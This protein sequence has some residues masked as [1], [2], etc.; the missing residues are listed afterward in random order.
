MNENTFKIGDKVIS[1]VFGEGTILDVD[2]TEDNLY[3]IRVLF[4]EKMLQYFTLTGQYTI[5]EKNPTH[6]I[7]LK[8]NILIQPKQEETIFQIGDKV[9]S[10]KFGVGFVIGLS[11][12]E[13]YPLKVSFETRPTKLELY[14]LQGKYYTEDDIDIQDPTK[15]IS[16]FIESSLNF[17]Q[18][19]KGDEVISTKFG[20]GV[21]KII[22][23]DELYPLY[24]KFSDGEYVCFTKEGYFD[25]DCPLDWNIT[26]IPQEKPRQKAVRQKERTVE[27]KIPCLDHGFVKL[28]N[29][30]GPVRRTSEL[31]ENGAIVHRSFDAD[32]IDPAKS[33]RISFGNQEIERLREQDLKLYEYLIKNRHTTPIEMLEVWLE[34]KLPIFVA[35]QFVRHRT[36]TINEISARYTQLPADWYIPEIVGGKSTTGA[37]QGQENNLS[38]TEQEG[39]KELLQRTCE[40]SYE[41]YKVAISTGVAP[42]H[43]RLFLH[44]NHYT[45]WIWKQDLH[46]LFHFLALRLHSHAQIEAR[47]YAQAIYDLL[48]QFLPKSMEYFD[49]YC[50]L[51]EKSGLPKEVLVKNIANTK[52]SSLSEEQLEQLY[53]IINNNYAN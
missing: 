22:R 6:D 30:S 2:T 14:T 50:R 13:R 46:N 35:R 17:S 34:M 9:I 47:I 4:P 7:S 10:K 41:S 29:I 49:K 5:T 45:T 43:A 48:K 3:P 20:R 40:D 12:H 21:V 36:A 1:Q 39:I 23:T 37:K 27:F 26:K 42:E 16:L 33:A 19:Q 51:P 31:D 32:D 44:V 25:T 11:D 28:L 18:F 15:D 24:V 52:F 38:V 8:R 53:H